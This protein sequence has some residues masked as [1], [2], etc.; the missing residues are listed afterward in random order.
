ML[1]E[2]FGSRETERDRVICAGW[3]GTVCERHHYVGRLDDHGKA[4]RKSVKLGMGKMDHKL[5]DA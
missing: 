1:H 2:I 3:E 5:E 4:T